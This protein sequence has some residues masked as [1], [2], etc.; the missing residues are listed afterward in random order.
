MVL[1]HTMYV[2]RYVY[3]IMRWCRGMVCMR[4]CEPMPQ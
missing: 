2:N 4:T 3:V 1:R